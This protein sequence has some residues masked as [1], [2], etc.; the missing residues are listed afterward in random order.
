MTN[1]PSELVEKL[2]VQLQSTGK[3]HH[4]AFHATDGADPEW[5]LWYAENLAP[6]LNALID[7]PLTR[8][9][10]VALLVSL[11]QEFNAQGG[12]PWPRFYAEQI[13][14]RY[15]TRQAESVSLY[16][17]DGCPFCQLV[18]AAIDDLKADVELRDVRANPEWRDELIEA[19]GRATVPVLRCVTQSGEV[20]WMPESRDII[21]YLRRRFG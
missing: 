6:A 20:R 19:R 2:V 10:I 8:S 13:A 1:N 11:D 7:E 17:F 21:R 16:H 3:E 18:R 5:P 14:Q 15:V 9:E 4:Q 12:K